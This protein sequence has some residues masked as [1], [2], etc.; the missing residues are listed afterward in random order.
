VPNI[1]RTPEQLQLAPGEEGRVSLALLL[2]QDIYAA[3]AQYVGALHI[4]GGGEP[5]IEIALRIT[6]TD[7][8]P[9]AL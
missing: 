2:D 8:A 5:H 4:T 9:P 1:T 6:A 3:G 7:G